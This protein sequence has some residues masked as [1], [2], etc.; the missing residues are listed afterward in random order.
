MIETSRLVRVNGRGATS[1]FRGLLE[2]ASTRARLDGEYLAAS[3]EVAS[4]SGAHGAAH[5]LL[6]MNRMTS[7]AA[8][9]DARLALDLKE[10]DLGDTVEVMRGGEV[11][12][13]HARVIAR[14]PPDRPR[15]HRSAGAEC[16]Q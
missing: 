1:I 10:N 11:N 15:C 12:L 7:V 9:A 3:G 8:R 16:V 6:E 13:S 4:R 2:W 5:R 14:E